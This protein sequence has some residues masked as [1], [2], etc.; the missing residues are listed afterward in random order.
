MT[1]APFVE[2]TIFCSTEYDSVED[3]KWAGNRLF[4]VGF[5][6]FISEWDLKTCK[7]LQKSTLV[8]SNAWC[9]D[10]NAANTQIAVGTEEGYVNI[11]SVIDNDLAYTKVFDKQEGRIVSCCFDKTGQF[12]VTGSLDAIR[13]WNIESGHAIHKIGTGRSEKNRETI[14]WALAVLSDFTIVSGDSRG[15]L[16]FFD[17]NMGTQLESINLSK[18]DI[19]CIAVDEEEQ[20][21]ICSG[22]DPA[23]KQYKNIV[24]KKEGGS[25]KRWVRD[26]PRNV[27]QHDVR[28]MV[29][30]GSKCISGGIDG[31]LTVSS[32]PPKQVNRYGPFLQAPSVC[33]AKK[34]RLILLRY[35]NYLEIWRMGT[36]ADKK[37]EFIHHDDPSVKRQAFELQQHPEKMLEMR[38]KHDE[39]VV[40][41]ALSSDGRWLAYANISTARLFRFQVAVDDKATSSLV[42]VKAVPK[43]YFTPCRAMV[44]SGD[45]STLFLVQANNRIDALAV[46]EDGVEFMYSIV[47]DSGEFKD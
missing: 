1:A 4:S 28:S 39:N 16:T 32:F 30:L 29:S 20:T 40:C 13:I 5:N 18:A 37:I 34:A 25:Q 8:G 26:I 7:V 21:L 14:V 6:D 47:D 11:L 22:V 36:A 10:V 24:V 46:T 27:H 43:K 9:L 23:I 12:L 15:R 2:K 45:D 35:V 44:F 33:V 31:H 41:A 42:E 17:G 3:L 19:L 38:S